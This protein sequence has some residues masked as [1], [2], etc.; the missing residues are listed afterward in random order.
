MAKIIIVG[1]PDSDYQT[2]EALLHNHGL[3]PAWPSKRDGLLP[4]EINKLLL[5]SA[6]SSRPSENIP[7]TSKK[8]PQH[9]IGGVW[10]TL[11]MDLLLS[12]M[13]QT[14]WGWSDPQALE[15]LEYWRDVDNDIHFIL[16]YDTPHSTL[17]RNPQQTLTDQILEK[18]LQE[19]SAYNESL[20][21]FYTANKDRCLLIH[22]GQAG[23]TT[24]KYLKQISRHIEAPW[25][26]KKNK[27]AQKFTVAEKNHTLIL[28]NAPHP[29][30]QT[31]LTTFLANLLIDEN[32]ESMKL[33]QKLQQNATLPL[34]PAPHSEH[35]GREITLRAWQAMLQ[36]QQEQSQLIT[37]S[38]AYKNNIEMLTAQ[39]QQAE[40][41]LNTVRSS[42]D[43]AEQKLKDAQTIA[44]EYKQQNEAALQKQA[45]LEKEKTDLKEKADAAQ[46]DIVSFKTAQSALEEEN[47]LLLEQLHL[48][49]EKLEETH[50]E[51]QRLASRPVYYGAAERVKN[52]LPYQLGA[53]M[54]CHSKSIGGCLKMPFALVKT[55]RLTAKRQKEQNRELPPVNFYN[56]SADIERVHKHLSYQLGQSFL[57]C[58]R[59]PLRWLVMPFA[60][61]N[62]AR[63]FKRNKNKI[64]V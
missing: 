9:Q 11:A 10:N 55:A 27:S 4:T 62:T 48:V 46:K 12:N 6:R 43:Q 32:S 34:K 41:Q 54:I 45:Q 56:D 1:H 24:K 57:V 51:K 44:S 30:V 17:T 14:L 60:L 50:L 39:L 52:E 3:S 63:Q 15:L 16:V 29:S 28:D 25:Q 26:I 47:T 31:G 19:W 53:T 58:V 35:S 5:Q 21:D 64:A 37:N 23:R 7:L 8:R 2:V 20:L 40:K 59:N 36:Q 33:Y 42:H 38:L 22:S 49:Q 13:E 18:K 61:A